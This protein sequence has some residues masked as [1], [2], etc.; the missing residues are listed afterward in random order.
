[1]HAYLFNPENDLA[2]AAGVA[3]YTPPKNAALLASSGALMPIWYAEPGSMVI[4]NQ[5]CGEW[6]EQICYQYG[7]DVTISNRLP[8]D[9]VCHAWGWSEYAASRFATAGV[10]PHSLP[11]HI[12]LAE[13]RN[14]SHRRTS[15]TIINKLAERLPFN[16]EKRTFEARNA[17]EV[18]H[19]MSDDR[20]FYF[21]SPWSST[22]RGVASSSSMTND[23]ALRRCT[24]I[25]AHQG[26]VLLEPEVEKIEDFAMLFKSTDGKV[27]FM[28][29]SLFSN[30]GNAYSGNMLLPDSEIRR[31]LSQYV[32]A[33]HLDALSATLAD[34]L[35]EIVGSRYDGYMGVD[36]MIFRDGT[37]HKIDVCTELN[38]RM[39]M[40]IVAWLWRQKFL[41][42]GVSAT[43]SVTY[44]NHLQ[45]SPAII[46]NHRLAG[47]TQMLV[48]PGQPFT[49]A[50]TAV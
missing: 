24:G 13:I 28:G 1:M 5:P 4:A 25:I 26:S 19:F 10:A 36:M 20:P 42:D 49:I 23:E 47:G 29:Y 27:S 9:A 16:V 40:G 3:N 6:L 22:G 46:E 8:G 17:D 45:Q 2:L 7:L 15:I 12:R 50:V 35:T 48:P 44:G 14:L 33:Q 37:K 32:P 41:A 31:R 18:R 39:T 11:N 30:E 38:L 21:K 34:V 43:L